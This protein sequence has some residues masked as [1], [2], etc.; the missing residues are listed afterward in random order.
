MLVGDRGS[1]RCSSSVVDLRSSSRTS[2]NLQLP[3]ACARCEK[4][5]TGGGRSGPGAGGRRR[6]SPK[7]V[8]HLRVPTISLPPSAADDLT[9]PTRV[10]AKSG[11][12][13]PSAGAL[14]TRR[15]SLPVH[16]LQLRVVPLM[17]RSRDSDDV[18]GVMM[19]SSSS[20]D[21]R[22]SMNALKQ[23]EDTER[24]LYSR[25]SDY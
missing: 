15:V 11:L 25:L 4:V 12:L 13:A 23:D 19:T 8:H 6:A 24:Q 5:A 9:S 18:R 1:G 7:C 20:T 3:P 22:L 16:G 17:K 10:S 21:V 14:T 2:L